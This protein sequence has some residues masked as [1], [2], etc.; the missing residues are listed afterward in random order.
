VKVINPKIDPKPKQE[1]VPSDHKQ[2]II[3]DSAAFIKKKNVIDL[4]DS[5]KW[6]ED[7]DIMTLR[8]VLNELKDE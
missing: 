6:I 2:V 8:E 5:S 1:D 7:Y 4:I 3:L